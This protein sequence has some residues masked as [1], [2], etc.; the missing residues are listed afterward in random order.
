MNNL[1]TFVPKK[2]LVLILALAGAIL[3]LGA[4]LF[5]SQPKNSSTNNPVIS[6]SPSKLSS[7]QKTVIGQTT[8]NELTQAYPGG[9]EQSIANGDSGYLLNS[10]LDARPNQVVFRNKISSFERTVIMGETGSASPKISDLILKYG[11]AERTIRGS[12]F[13]G[14][15]M[16]TYIY[17]NKGLAFIGNPNTDEIFEIQTFLPITVEEYLSSY[18][19]DIK[20]YAEVRE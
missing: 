13:Y 1:H 18:G 19:E 3:I 6:Q 20:E 17:S 7:L 11:Q 15:M 2:T 14:R 12:K 10:K 4:I 5:I 9:K 8:V 16:N